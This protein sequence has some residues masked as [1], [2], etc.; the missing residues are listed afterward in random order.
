MRST[1]RYQSASLAVFRG[2]GL[3]ASAIDSAYSLAMKRGDQLVW[4]TKLARPQLQWD[5]RFENSNSLRDVHSQV[6]LSSLDALV[7]EP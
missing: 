6:V 7:T 1:G 5:Q 4:R 2:F 3:L